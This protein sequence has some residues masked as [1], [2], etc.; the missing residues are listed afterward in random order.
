MGGSGG[1]QTQTTQQQLPPELSQASN[2]YL[3]ALRQLILP[4]GQIT[5]SPLPYQAVAP[6]SPQQQQGMN[7]VSQ[8]TYGPGEARPN[9]AWM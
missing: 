2:V 9:R 5:Q 1:G 7:L 3:N 4:G 8:E 6:F